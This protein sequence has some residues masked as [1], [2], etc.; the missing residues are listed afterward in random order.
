VWLWRSLAAVLILGTAAARL[1]YLIYFCQLDLAPDEAHY[2][3][4]SRH[5]DWSYYSKGPL[6]AYLI[7]LGC[8]AAGGWSEQMVGSQMVAV[9]LPALCC[10]SL[11]LAGLYVLAAQVYRREDFA[12]ALVAGALTLPPIAAGSSLMTIDAPYSCCWCWS[13]VLAYQAVFGGARWAWPLLGLVAGLGILAKYTMVLW[14]PSFGLFLLLTPSW[15][16]LLRKPGVWLATVVAALCCLPIIVWNVEHDWVSFFHVK[17]LAEGQHATTQITWFGPLAYLG[18]QFALLLGFWFVVWARAMWDQAPWRDVTDPQR[19]LWWLSAPTFVLFLLFGFTTGGGEP[20]WPV[21]A[22]LS[23]MVL[24]LGWLV[25]Q[26][27]SP[28][29]AYRR[30]TFSG[31]AVT[32]LLGIG[33]TLFI[34]RTDVAYPLLARLTGPPAVGNPCPMR[35]LDPTCRLRGWQ[36]LAEAVE[37]EVLRLRREGIEPVVAADTW[38]LPGELGFYC[39]EHP[40]VYSLGLAIGSRHSQYDFWHPNPIDDPRQFRGRTFIFVGASPP[41]VLQKTFRSVEPP[42]TVCYATQG[43]PLATW[44]VTVCHGFRGIPSA[45]RHIRNY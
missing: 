30:L 43:Q 19:F 3:D 7:R 36:R 33:L 5:L 44:Q 31:V 12:F 10:G 20:N 45:N 2:W 15:R 18:T 22:Y 37:E 40:Q 29:V 42:R 8:W 16:H 1:V 38:T 35:R 32:A 9:R 26:L 28:F 14:F 27:Q 39:R 4:W 25:Q 17:G 11:L 6:V 23:G 34:H 21:T 41:Q 24:M 13:L